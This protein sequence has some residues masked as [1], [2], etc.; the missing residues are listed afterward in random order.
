M[1]PEGLYYTEDHEWLR[2]EGDDAVVGIT[3]HA[4]KALGD[5]TFVELPT[6]G[7][8]LKARDAMAV[9]ESVKA[10]SDVYA[11]VAG[12][13]AAVNTALEAAPETINQSP[14]DEGWVCRLSK[15]DKAGLSG[16]MKAGQYEAFLAKG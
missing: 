8:T 16:L 7:K 6:V 3:H 5:I 1:I 12:A 4:Q 14:Y 11:P 13:V 9:I 10:A 2:M 15:V